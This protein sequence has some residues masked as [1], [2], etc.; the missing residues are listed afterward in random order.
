[1]VLS[2]RYAR[3]ICLEGITRNSVS[4]FLRLKALRLIVLRQIGR[5]SS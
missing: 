3:E 1:M 5:F 2:K 4:A